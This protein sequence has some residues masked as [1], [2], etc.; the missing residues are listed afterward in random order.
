MLL[1]LSARPP[2][3]PG[4][5]AQARSLGRQPRSSALRASGRGN[6][7]GARGKAVRLSGPLRSAPGPRRPVVSVAPPRGVFGPHSPRAF[8]RA[9]PPAGWWP[10]RGIRHVRPHLRGE[11]PE[12]ANEPT[13]WERPGHTRRCATVASFRTWRGSR[14]RVVPTTS[15]W[16]CR[17]S[18]RR[19]WDSNPRYP[20]RYARVP[21]V[22]LQP[23][24]HLS[25]LAESVGFEPTVPFPVRLI[26]SQVPSTTRPALQRFS[27]QP[28]GVR[29]PW[30]K[31]VSRSAHS[32]S[33]TP[34]RTCRRWLCGSAFRSSSPPSAPV[35]GLAAP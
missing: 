21:G 25:S 7:R 35:L 20:F 31:R 3:P 16:C 23:L 8:C 29:S 11:G 6:V 1:H 4:A 2:S 10:P 24:G 27:F 28:S 15:C 12:G 22:C 17:T 30:K 19:G 32:A 26:S 9:P 33:S 34:A 18:Q 5:C 13:T 14:P